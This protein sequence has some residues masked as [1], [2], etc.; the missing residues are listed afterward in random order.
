[1]TNK[2]GINL[3]ICRQMKI[4]SSV[5]WQ[6]TKKNNSF[7]V[8][9]N[10]QTFTHDPLNLTGLHNA[11]SAGLSNDGAISL[12]ATKEKSKKAS[13]PVFTLLHKHKSHNKI[14]KKKNSTS[15]LVYSAQ[16][17]RRG[18]NRIGKII[19]GLPTLTE[20]VRRVALKRAQRLHVA[21]R[22]HVKGVAAKKEEKK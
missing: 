16:P 14:T 20:K 2:Y 15:G 18:I 10:G 3:C 4:P 9:F 11:S 8:K 19:K 21:T 13:R 1:M 5:L 17:L 22:S 12:Q 7:L 6:L